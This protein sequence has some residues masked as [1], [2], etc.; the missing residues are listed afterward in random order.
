M[1]GSRELL[2]APN[3]LR[4]VRATFTAHG[5]SSVKSLLVWCNN[6]FIIPNLYD[7]HLQLAYSLIRTA[8]MSLMRK[9]SSI[10]LFR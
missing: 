4:T 10:E 9:A 7:T 3:P 1:S 8:G 6:R 2:P 5:S